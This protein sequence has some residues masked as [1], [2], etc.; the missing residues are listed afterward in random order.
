L[1]N[2]RLK[3]ACV[4]D[5]RAVGS[6]SRRRPGPIITA[7]DLR[8]GVGHIALS[9]NLAVWVPAFAGTTWI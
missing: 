6:S 1:M 7:V 2:G 4:S 8:H 5:N 3:T 9:M